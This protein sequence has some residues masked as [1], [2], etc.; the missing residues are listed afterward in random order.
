MFW[1]L[2]GKF[3]Q[4]TMNYGEWKIYI[5]KPR[6][7]ITVLMQKNTGILYYEIPENY[8]DLCTKILLPYIY[9]IISIAKSVIKIECR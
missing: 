4:S 6:Q 8:I 5:T 3:T 2:L 1:H 7:T 9:T